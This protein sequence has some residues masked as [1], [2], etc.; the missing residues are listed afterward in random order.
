MKKRIKRGLK[1]GDAGYLKN[2]SDT[3]SAMEDSSSEDGDDEAEDNDNDSGA[4]S[5]DE[6][7]SLH[8]Q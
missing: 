5:V 8:E 6:T 3:D 4:E 2:A 7:V 1:E